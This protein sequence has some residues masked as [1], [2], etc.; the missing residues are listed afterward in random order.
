[1]ATRLSVSGTTTLVSAAPAH[2]V[3]RRVVS[4]DA[5]PVHGGHLI[6]TSASHPEPARAPDEKQKAVP[7]VGA[8][9]RLPVAVAV[10]V[11]LAGCGELHLAY[12]LLPEGGGG[13]GGGSGPVPMRRVP[14]GVFWQGCNQAVDT[15]CSDSEKPYREVTLSAFEMDET[16]VTQGAYKNCVDGGSCRAPNCDWSTDSKRPTH[17][18]VCVDWNDAKTYCEWAGKR[19]PTEAEWEKAARGTDGRVYPWG[20]EAPTCSLVNF[21]GCVETTK[22]VGSTPQGDSP[23]GLKDMAGNVWEWVADR[24]DGNYYASAPATNPT[25]PSGGWSRVYRGGAFRVDARFVRAS[26]RSATD[27]GLRSD[28]LGFRCARS[29]PWVFDMTP[30]NRRHADE[31]LS[32]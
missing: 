9:R 10:V 20:K 28:G 4:T 24:Y 32:S 19:L 5:A 30:P 3:A 12:E 22:A 1:M 31:P 23:Y 26:K 8:W 29:V 16:E 14:A 15:D 2:E 7:G 27:P 13:G 6:V 11:L 18:V 25:G 21:S 17:P